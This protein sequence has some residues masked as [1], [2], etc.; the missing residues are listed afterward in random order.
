MPLVWRALCTGFQGNGT[1]F[2]LRGENYVEAGLTLWATMPRASHYVQDHLIVVAM[3]QQASVQLF[4]QACPTGHLVKAAY[5]FILQISGPAHGGLVNTN[6]RWVV[7]ITEENPFG[8]KLTH[9]KPAKLYGGT[10]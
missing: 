7:R 6:R 1:W 4:T 10:I 2:Q 8:G 9:L 3:A 5:L